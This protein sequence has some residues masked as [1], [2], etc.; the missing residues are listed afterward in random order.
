ML[1]RPSLVTRHWERQKVFGTSSSRREWLA[2]VVVSRRR[3]PP[4]EAQY[5]LQRAEGAQI[6]LKAL[7]RLHVDE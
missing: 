5:W 6:G 3:P 1:R 2:G 7:D 4:G